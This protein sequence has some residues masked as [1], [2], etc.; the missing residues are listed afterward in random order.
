MD[1]V[2]TGIIKELG[3]INF[4]IGMAKA[5]QREIIK[6][7]S[8]SFKQQNIINKN[9]F[10]ICVGLIII[11]IGIN[12]DIKSIKKKLVRLEQEQSKKGE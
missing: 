6:S 5:G 11:N 10:G 7:V 8:A 12:S 9:L 3:N 2:S 4:R 1:E